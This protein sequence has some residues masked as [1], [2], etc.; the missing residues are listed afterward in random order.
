MFGR[1]V[2]WQAVQAYQTEHRGHLE[3]TAPGSWRVRL[4]EEFDSFPSDANRSPEVGL[5]QRAGL[6]VRRA[7]QLPQLPVSGI[8]EDDV[9]ATERAFGS[10][11][12]LSDGLRLGN[13]RRDYEDAIGAVLVDE[14]VEHMYPA[15]CCDDLLVFLQCNPAHRIAEAGGCASD[16]DNA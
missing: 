7:L 16:C 9:D 10:S 3:E 11:E 12:G 2:E 8:V 15:R 14:V 6:R 13:V 4:A 5:H 1:S